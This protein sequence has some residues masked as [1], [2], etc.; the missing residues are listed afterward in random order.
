MA[1]RQTLAAHFRVISSETAAV[2][3]TQ[4]TN[5][6]IQ[7]SKLPSSTRQEVYA[8]EKILPDRYSGRNDELKEHSR[9]F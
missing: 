9:A 5:V 6:G 7:A 3:L 2:V 4:K 1:G 8:S